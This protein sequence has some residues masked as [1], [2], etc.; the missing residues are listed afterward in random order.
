MAQ[1]NAI[2]KEELPSAV[3]VTLDE[4]PAPGSVP[5]GGMKVVISA[6]S[7]ERLRRIYSGSV[8]PGRV[9]GTVQLRAQVKRQSFSSGLD[10]TWPSAI[11]RQML[12]GNF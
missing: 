6:R 8:D 9:D 4:P 5:V 12:P 7:K 11:A 1:G 3:G 10:S 2:M